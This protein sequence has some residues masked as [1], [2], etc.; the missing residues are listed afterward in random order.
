MNLFP[1]LE[2]DT[3]MYVLVPGVGACNR[4]VMKLKLFKLHMLAK[5]NNNLSLQQVISIK[6]SL[7]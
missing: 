3:H 5:E 6:T 7:E 2:E 4:R 1:F